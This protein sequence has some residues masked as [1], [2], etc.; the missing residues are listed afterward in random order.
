MAGGGQARLGEQV[1]EPA[2][3]ASAN[4]PAAPGGGGGSSPPIAARI[5]PVSQRPGSPQ[6]STAIGLPGRATR[7]SSRSAATGSAAYW[8]AL[9][10]VTAVNVPSA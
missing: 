4:G 5:D 10:D 1:F 7:L 3:A 9:N 6:E 8:T 2:R